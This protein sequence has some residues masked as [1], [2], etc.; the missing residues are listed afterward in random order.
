MCSAILGI[1]LVERNPPQPVRARAAGLWRHNRDRRRERAAADSARRALCRG[2]RCTSPPRAGRIPGPRP[3]ARRS[4]AGRLCQGAP[5]WRDRFSARRRRRRA[6]RRGGHD[7]RAQGRAHRHQFA[8]VPARRHRSAGWPERRC[9][10]ARSARQARPKAG[11]A[12]AHDVA[13]GAISPS[14]RERAGAPPRRRARRYRGG[15]PSGGLR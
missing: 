13:L 12:D 11:L 8:P 3:S 14:C 1:K 9:R 6:A 15:K 7:H 10:L 5:A 2:W 4:L